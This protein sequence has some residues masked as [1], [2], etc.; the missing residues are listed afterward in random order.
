M[1]G[2]LSEEAKILHIL[3]NIKACLM[4][5]VLESSISHVCKLCARIMRRLPGSKHTELVQQI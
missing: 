3:G 2:P 1:I 4:Q 5:K